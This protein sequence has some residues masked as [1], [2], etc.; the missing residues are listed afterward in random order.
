MSAAEPPTTGAAAAPE[1]DRCS[2]PGGAVALVAALAIGVTSWVLDV[3]ADAPSLSSCKPVEE[4]GNSD[5][6]RRRRQQARRGRLRRGA[7]PRLRFDADAGG[8]APGDDRDRGRA[9]LRARRGRHGGD[10]PRRRSR[11]SKPARPSRAARRSPSSWSATSASPTPSDDLERKI[12]EAKLAEEYSE[13]H[14]KRRDPRPVPEHGLLRD[15]RR[16]HRGRRPGGIADLLLA[17]G[18]EARPRPRGDCSPACRRRR[19]TTTRSSTRAGPASAATTSS[20]RWPSSA[21]SARPR[22]AA[23]ERR[24]LGLE[25]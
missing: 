7:R 9:L 10:R 12:I 3:A 22:R 17:A 11:T 1:Q 13:R 14:S 25:V 24:G 21:S 16:Q 4:G 15:D 19:P 6:L 23:A 8:A 5:D 20:R 2:S 18:L